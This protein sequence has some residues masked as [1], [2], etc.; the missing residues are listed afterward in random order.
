MTP[1]LSDWR[2]AHRL[3]AVELSQ[4]SWRRPAIARAQGVSRCAVDRWLSAY[5]RGG[6]Q[7][8]KSRMAHGA[9]PRLSPE[10][11]QR[12]PELLA[13]GLRAFGFPDDR[14]T[15][16]RV[17]AVIQRVRGQLSSLARLA[18]AQKPGL[19]APGPGHAGPPAGG[20]LV[21]PTVASPPGGKSRSRLH[22]G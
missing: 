14:W 8:L 2:E 9:K 4:R 3:R 12:L 6:P 16:S 19:D 20:Q 17:A 13:R 21:R 11:F 7:A 1:A 10:Q 22:P 5:R 18:Q 15:A